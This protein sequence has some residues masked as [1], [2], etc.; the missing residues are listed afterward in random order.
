MGLSVTSPCA[1]SPVCTTV[2]RA[3]LLSTPRRPVH[4]PATARALGTS[5]DAK[6]GGRCTA[7]VTSLG[8]CQTQTSTTSSTLN[9]DQLAGSTAA[10]TER[11]EALA[12]TA[13]EYSAMKRRGQLP[14]AGKG[15][16]CSGEGEGGVGVAGSPGPASRQRYKPSVDVTLP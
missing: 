11:E 3:R 10:R 5:S 9:P 2:R 12:L 13:A 16:R 14:S 1:G 4:D 8:S 6:G 15:R 7:H